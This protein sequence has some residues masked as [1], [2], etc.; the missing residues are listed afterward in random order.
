MKTK[1]VDVLMG[2]SNRIP[3]TNYF[4]FMA[5]LDNCNLKKV[6]EVVKDLQETYPRWIGNIH[7][8]RS[9]RGNYHLYSFYKLRKKQIMLMLFHLVE[10]GVLDIKYLKF[11]WLRPARVLR[12][13][14]KSR[15]G[16]PQ[17]I[18]TIHS[19]LCR[20]KELTKMRDITLSVLKWSKNQKK[21][22][23][24]KIKKESN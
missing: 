14:K 12:F 7:I 21:V 4:Y 2:F 20:R 5:D 10:K 19:P 22:T 18:E 1:N 16:N 23:I 17:Y 9:S 24:L 15:K 6:R 3:R 11:S 8:I 13:S